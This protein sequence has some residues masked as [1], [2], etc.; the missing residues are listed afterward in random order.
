MRSGRNL[1]R[2]FLEYYRLIE[3]IP[4]S[5]MEELLPKKKRRSKTRSS[6][7][8]SR[9]NLVNRPKTTREHVRIHYTDLNINYDSSASCDESPHRYQPYCYSS[10]TQMSGSDKRNIKWENVN[11]PLPQVYDIPPQPS[12]SIIDFNSITTGSLEEA[13]KNM[14]YKQVKND[15]REN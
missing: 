15:K 9:Y 3:V 14:K 2:A 6:R 8:S 10:R 5:V 11:S 7:T 1:L 12:L 13:L 4:I